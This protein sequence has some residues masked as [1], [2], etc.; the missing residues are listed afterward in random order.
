MKKINNLSFIILG[1]LLIVFAIWSTT[2]NSYSSLKGLDEFR[3]IEKINICENSKHHRTFESYTISDQFS[4]DWSECDLTGVQLRNIILK[5]ADLRNADL[6]GADLTGADLTG[7]DL[8]GAK[9]FGVDLR[10]AD[11]YRANLEN[12]ILD[13]ADLRGYNNGECQSQ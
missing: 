5:N 2:D 9:L 3:T 6:S 4:I 11:L 8:T 10:Q 7:A 12:S 13:G 1:V